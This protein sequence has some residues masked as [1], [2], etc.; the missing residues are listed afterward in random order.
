[1]LSPGRTNM[2]STSW[3]HMAIF[4]GGTAAR[5]LP[6]SNLVDMYNTVNKTWAVHK[7]RTGRDLLACASV[8]DYTLFAGGSDP[9]ETASVEIF[10]HVLSQWSYANLSVARKKPEAVTVGDFVVIVGGEIPKASQ[11]GGATS[12]PELGGYSAT[13]DIFNSATNA[14]TTGKLISARQYFGAARAGCESDKNGVAVF[15]GG[16][17]NDERLASVD[18]YDP[19]TGVH[20]S[21]KNLSHARS[22]IVG[23]TVGSDGRFAVFG[24]GNIDSVAKLSLDFYD[25]LNDE[26][27]SSF[28]HAPNV[29]NGVGSVGSMAMFMGGDGKVDV[30]ALDGDCSGMP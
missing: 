29:R 17:Y 15:A 12:R 14:W 30:I 7:M 10:N 3:K 8:G 4:A 18:I 21:S 6:K 19:M 9:H 2:C 23:S 25:G 5:G 28:G 27:A 13:M 26:W 16:F 20:L 22:N 24:S 1:M 11:T